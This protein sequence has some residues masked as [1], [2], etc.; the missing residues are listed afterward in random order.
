MASKPP[1]PYAKAPAVGATPVPLRA[2]PV[3]IPA[4]KSAAAAAAATEP[5]SKNKKKRGILRA[6]PTSSV[7]EPPS[8]QQKTA[9]T[10]SKPHA[11]KVSV[12]PVTTSAADAAAATKPSPKIKILHAPPASTAEP[13]SKHQKIATKQSRAPVS[14][15]LVLELWDLSKA[16]NTE[17]HSDAALNLFT[18]Y[19]K[20]MGLPEMPT[21]KEFEVD[22]LREF[23]V[24]TFTLQRAAPF[25]FILTTTLCHM[26][27][28][29]TTDAALMSP[30]LVT[31]AKS[32]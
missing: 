19:C 6:S 28:Q 17:G 21:A 22:N 2:A 30:W 5:S 3:T 13:P 4:T 24:R 29:N 27:I 8:K 11:S 23:V 32:F 1:N 16:D 25:P 7:T 12:T 14:I 10:Q 26:R 20:H 9:T 31:L 18:A 15:S